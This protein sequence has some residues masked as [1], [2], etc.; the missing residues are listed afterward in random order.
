MPVHEFDP[1]P[2]DLPLERPGHALE[3]RMG[4]KPCTAEMIQVAVVV[5]KHVECIDLS[6]PVEQGQ[7]HRD[8]RAQIHL[9]ELEQVAQDN[10]F[11]LLLDD[12]I[13]EQV[14]CL[15]RSPRAKLSLGLPSP[16]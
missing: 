13:E 6:K 3:E 15:S 4:Q 1:L 16:I 10:K 7:V 8:D 5:P 11:S 12:M 9:P 14:S 2:A